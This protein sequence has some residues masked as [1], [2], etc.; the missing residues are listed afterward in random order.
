MTRAEYEAKYGQKPEA[1]PVRMTQKEYNNKYATQQ[2]PTQPV[3]QSATVDSV[4]NNGQKV[5]NTLFPGKQV[6]ESIGTLGGYALTALKEKLGLAPKGATAAYDTSAP[7]VLQTAGDIAAGAATVAGL[8]APLPV[9]KTILGTA[10]KAALQTGALSALSAGGSTLA[11]GG[12]AKDVAINAFKSGLTGAAIGGAAGAVTKALTPTIAK[13]P[14]GAY[15]NALRVLNR[16][17]E[18]GKSPAKFLADEGVWGGLG[19]IQ[20]AA[21]DGAKTESTKI[22]SAAASAEGVAPGYQEI[23]QK[24]VERLS[25]TLGGLFSNAQI[26]QLVDDVP[27]AGIRDSKDP[28]YWVTLNNIREKLGSYVGDSKWVM[29]NPSEKV[30]A[31]QEMYRVIS[32]MVKDAT[33]TTEEFSRLS[34][35]LQ[36]QKVVARAIGIADNKYGIG[37]YD[38]LSGTGG[39]VAGGLSSDGS[40]TDRLK[41][42]AI[43]GVLGL[44]AERLANS[45]ALKTGLAQL[46]TKFPFDASGK[47]GRDAVMETLGRIFN[48]TSS[49]SPQPDQ[50]QS[51]QMQLQSSPDTTTNPV[52]STLQGV[53]NSVM[54]GL[55][56]LDQYAGYKNPDGTPTA[57]AK[58]MPKIDPTGAM[59]AVKNV[60]ANM[61]IREFRVLSEYLAAK[62]GKPNAYVPPGLFT[63]AM[64]ILEKQ[65]MKLKNKSDSW[66]DSTIS[67]VVD[68]YNS[69]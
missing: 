30:R 2:E 43:G 59:G 38:V 50:P 17:K 47:I 7:T 32:G 23:K 29:S 51:Q 61:T 41:N 63:E 19:S 40:V 27:V 10:G 48:E 3:Q 13:T 66:I 45:P 57:K 33:G 58:E 5:A 28:L 52:T 53:G 55:N 18:K 16:L 44:G 68:A 11:N 67:E 9:A 56:K 1:A 62:F 20:K 34:N 69:L 4:L 8:K 39:A 12:T 64:T 26:E 46:I 25:K 24:V 49:E 6:G 65:G 54:E 31:T 35:W 37:L 36:T 15:N 60:A 42:A 14:E 22:A 21:V